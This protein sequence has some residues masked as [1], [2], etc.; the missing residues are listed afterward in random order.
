M[1][2]WLQK[3]LSPVKDATERWV[4]FAQSIEQFWEEN[5][6]P[7]WQRLINLRSIYT[8]DE[9][10][11]ARIIADKGPYFEDEIPT[12]N[13][14]FSVARREF[15]L[16][17]KETM[18]PLENTCRRLRITADWRPLFALVKDTYGDA[19]YLETDNVVHYLDGS[20][21]LGGVR[22]Y[23]DNTWALMDDPSK[24]LIVDANVWLTQ[25]HYMTS[26]GIVLVELPSVDDFEDIDILKRRVRQVKPL[27]IVFDGIRYSDLLNYTVDTAAGG[28]LFD[29]LYL[30]GTWNLGDGGCYLFDAFQTAIEFYDRVFI[31]GR[32]I[33]PQ[34]NPVTVRMKFGESGGGYPAAKAVSKVEFFDDTHVGI[35]AV[36]QND[37]AVGAAI[38]HVKLTLNGILM[39]EMALS[40]SKIKV[41]DESY[42]VDIILTFA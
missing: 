29:Q 25:G 39:G 22:N 34:L 19:F 3:R 26:R 11:K 24:R 8:A 30:D 1:T 9:A 15:E 21:T 36:L 7:E 17:Q 18:F 6:D 2:G 31:E 38:S 27:H 28:C 16:F 32:E 4:Q 40:A 23:L 37:E 12:V 20:W 10:G 5:F 42:S 33:L 13:V 14:P 35:T 41:A